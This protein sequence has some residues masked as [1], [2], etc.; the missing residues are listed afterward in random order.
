MSQLTVQR[1]NSGAIRDGMPGQDHV[2]RQ[3]VLKL[4]EIKDSDIRILNLEQCRDAV[5]KCIH[6]GGAFSAVIPMVSLFYGGFMDLDI[7]EP[8]KRGQDMF[9]LSK[10]H[11]V[12]T[13]ASIYAELGYFDRAVLRAS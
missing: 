13:L 4:L 8:T 3:A 12:A 6:A 1:V 10:G 9:V 7:A 11:A 5:D 2:M